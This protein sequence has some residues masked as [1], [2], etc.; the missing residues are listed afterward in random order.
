MS[1]T[2][3]ILRP[4]QFAKR[5]G[6]ETLVIVRAMH[7]GTLPRIKMTDGTYGIPSAALT[8]FSPSSEAEQ[9]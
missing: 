9:A 4:S 6:V 3:E 2:E 1:T 7:E 8:T 5:L